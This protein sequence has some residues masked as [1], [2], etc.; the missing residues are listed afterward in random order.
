VGFFEEGAATS[1][2][3]ARGSGGALSSPVG[4]R[5]EPLPPEGFALFSALRMA[6][7]DTII[8]FIV[9]Y[10][11]AIGGARPR[12]PRLAYAPA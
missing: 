1:S 6:S 5:A 11:A 7:P 2:L 8:V 12:W 3:P 9:D 10:Y 4:F